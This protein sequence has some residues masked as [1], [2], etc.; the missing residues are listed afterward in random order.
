M[1]RLY[2]QIEKD[3]Q[4]YCRPSPLEEDVHFTIENGVLRVSAKTSSLGP[5]YHAHLANSLRKLADANGFEWQ[6]DEEYFDETG[7]F[8]NDNFEVLQSEHDKIGHSLAGLLIKQAELG[9]NNFR[10]GLPADFNVMGLND[11]ALTSLGPR[12]KSFFENF[13]A[14]AYFIWWEKNLSPQ[15]RQYMAEA[16]LWSELSWAA[17]LAPHDQVLAATALELTTD[18]ELP[19]QAELRSLIDAQ[20]PRAPTLDG[21]GYKR[22]HFRRRG[23]GHWT[24]LVPGYFEL[25]ADD[26]KLIWWWSNRSIYFS[27]LSFNGSRSATNEIRKEKRYDFSEEANGC[28]YSAKFSTDSE[29]ESY[30][31]LHGTVEAEGTV[32]ILTITMGD[33]SDREWAL[34]ILRSVRLSPPAADTN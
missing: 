13:S 19:W 9:M 10:L 11:F 7:Y 3:G 6:E 12:P 29:D 18:L 32:A 24:L 4:L 17:P 15:T 27:S 2:T 1:A 30:I 8:S 14:E 20:K 22:H 28:M 31:H 33:P 23:T 26:D 5:G 34:D 16:L 25:E 21:I